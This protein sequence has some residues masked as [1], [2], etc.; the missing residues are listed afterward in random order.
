MVMA[1]FDTEGDGKINFDE[2]LAGIRGRLNAT[3]L[4]ITDKAF[5]KFDKD[6]NGYIDEDDLKGVYNCSHN[7][8][9]TSGKKTE[10]EVY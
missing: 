9:V 6:G 4:A 5:A 8:E 10:H 1:A 2:F 3:R 7:P